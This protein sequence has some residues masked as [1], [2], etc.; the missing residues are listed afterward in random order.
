MATLLKR[1]LQKPSN[2]DCIT[3]CDKVVQEKQDI[4]MKLT[5]YLLLRRD[6][7]MPPLFGMNGYELTLGCLLQSLC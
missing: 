5:A 2:E 1:T 7:K 3:F 6:H 4:K